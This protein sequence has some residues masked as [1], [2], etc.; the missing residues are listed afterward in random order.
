MTIP[1]PVRLFHI[2]A[3]ANLQ[4]ICAAGALVSKNG[5]AAAG[6]AYQKIA[7]TNIQGIRAE[8]T[9]PRQRLLPRKARISKDGL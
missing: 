9:T 6:V 8:R 1:N 7:H 3:I 4:A 2:T 5:G